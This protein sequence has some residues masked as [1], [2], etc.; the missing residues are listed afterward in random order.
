VFFAAFFVSRVF[1]QIEMSD[2][3]PRSDESMGFYTFAEMNKSM[4]DNLS[5]LRK[6]AEEK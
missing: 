5:T 4:L 3:T 1:I 6:I 2:D